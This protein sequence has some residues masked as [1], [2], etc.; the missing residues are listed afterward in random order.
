MQTDR[1]T[2]GRINGQ[3]DKQL[4]FAANNLQHFGQAILLP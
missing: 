3:T 4:D 2:D 1:R